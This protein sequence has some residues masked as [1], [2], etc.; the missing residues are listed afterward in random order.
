MPTTFFIL[1]TRGKAH[2]MAFS[3][4]SKSVFHEYQKNRSKAKMQLGDLS[5]TEYTCKREKKYI[6]SQ[7][8]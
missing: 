1:A 5:N 3:D 6:C 7:V 4:Y 8:Y 2:R